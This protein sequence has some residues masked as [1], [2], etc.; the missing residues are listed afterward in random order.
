[1]GDEVFQL[2]PTIYGIGID[3]RALT[4]WWK[5]RSCQKDADIV[6]RFLQVFEGHG[7]QPGHIPRLFPALRYSD[8]A[9]EHA[10][11]SALTPEL[12]DAVG[13]LFGVRPEWIVG[14]DEHKYETEYCYKCPQRLFDVMA[15]L[16]EPPSLPLLAIS[17]VKFL[18]KNALAPQR[19]ELLAV[20]K[21]ATVGDMDVYRY[22]PFADGWE[23]TYAGCRI[24]LKAMVRALSRPVP[25]YKVTMEEMEAFYSGKIFPHSL[26]PRPRITNPSLEDYVLSSNE[27]HVSKE[28]DELPLVLQYL[29]GGNLTL[30]DKAI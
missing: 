5:S 23:W 13:K 1:M 29:A 6:S 21:A 30:V 20:E 19:I 10:L 12:V 2:K 27:S 26:V 4:R 18:D 24:Q 14:I 25:L 8:L 9:N 3:L 28:S 15:T 11:I 16:I 17:T 7:L 22:R